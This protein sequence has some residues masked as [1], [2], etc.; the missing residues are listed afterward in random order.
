VRLVHREAEGSW[1]AM[2]LLLAQ[3]ALAQK[4]RAKETLASSPGAITDVE[5]KL[6][7]AP[8]LDSGGRLVE[9]RSVR[10]RVPSGAP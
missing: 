4:H 5:A 2:Q 3:G 9:A 6:E 7:D 1:L 8:D 10:V